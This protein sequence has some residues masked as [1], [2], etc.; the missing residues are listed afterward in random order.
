MN[1][2]TFQIW[3]GANTLD[4]Q[5]HTDDMGWTSNLDFGQEANNP[6]FI[7]KN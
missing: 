2:I 5:S 4:M 1:D 6:N 7:M 3:I